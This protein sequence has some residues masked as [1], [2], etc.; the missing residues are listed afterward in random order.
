MKGD[1]I[2]AVY[3][4][5]A[6]ALL[7]WLVLSS[8]NAVKRYVKAKQNLINKC[9]E[10]L[11]EEADTTFIIETNIDTLLINGVPVIV[12]T[13]DSIPKYITNTEYINCDDYETN[14]Q[15]RQKEKTKRV[16]TRQESGVE[17][18]KA[19]SKAKEEKAKSY[20]ASFFLFG[21]SVGGA[22]I[23]LLMKKQRRKD[24]EIKPK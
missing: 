14:S 4:L 8:C 12:H 1:R 16:E 24:G 20:R 9:P 17:K 5:V 15:T 23:Y 10:C 22:L 19:K 21:F 3:M 18:V 13:V 11:S 6:F 7:G 2:T